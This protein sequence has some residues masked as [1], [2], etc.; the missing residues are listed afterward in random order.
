MGDSWLIYLS[1]GCHRTAS[2]QTVAFSTLAAHHRRGVDSSLAQLT[3]T[4]APPPPLLQRHMVRPTEATWSD[5]PEPLAARIV[6][7]AVQ[8]SDRT[9][10]QWLRISLVCRHARCTTEA[11]LHTLLSSDKRAFV[12]ALRTGGEDAQLQAD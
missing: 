8:R 1:S 6:R 9:V 5:L 11:M 4:A 2:V 10:T 7:L 3:S 12:M